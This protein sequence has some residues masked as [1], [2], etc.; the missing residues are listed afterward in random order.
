MGTS[1][2]ENK[3]PTGITNFMECLNQL[4]NYQFFPCN[5]VEAEF[6]RVINTASALGQLHVPTALAKQSRVKTL[7]WMPATNF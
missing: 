2:E 6:V 7:T 1:S 4:S 5:G 3:E